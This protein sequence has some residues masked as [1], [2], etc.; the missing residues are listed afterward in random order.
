M[1]MT[2][3]FNP[4][5]GQ[6]EFAP[7]DILRARRMMVVDRVFTLAYLRMASD[8]FSALEKDLRIEA[9]QGGLKAKPQSFPSKP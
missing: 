1:R 7:A 9:D 3:Q 8:L 6:V 4:V 5:I 2:P